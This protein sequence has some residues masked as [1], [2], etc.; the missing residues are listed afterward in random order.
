MFRKLRKKYYR[1]RNLYFGKI[2]FDFEKQPKRWELVNKIIKN[3]NYSDYLEIGCFN[4]ECFNM[5]NASHKTGV[6]PLKGGT[7][8]QTSDEFF[9]VNKK[10]YDIIFID[11]LHE[12]DQIKK[13][14]LNSIEFLNEGGTILCHDSLPEEYSDQT[15]PYSLGIWSG[16][17][18]KSIVEFRTLKNLDICVC[19]ID[20]GVTVIKIRPNNNLLSLEEKNFK[21]LSF[22]FYLKNYS[23]IMNIKNFEESI[24]F[25]K[26]Y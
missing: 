2:D 17:V 24:N 1:L 8:R 21:S 15:V 11:G 5:I 9:K 23:Q 22:K 18:W 14:I 19:T 10:K 3:N 4:N 20:R 7:I 25:A 6:D 26:E 16:D 13:D 12:Y